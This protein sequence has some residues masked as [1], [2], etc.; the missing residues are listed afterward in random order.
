MGFPILVRWHLS[1]ESG[2]R[3]WSFLTSTHWPI[4]V[5]SEASWSA[6]HQGFFNIK[7]IFPG[8]RIAIINIRWP[9]Y[10]YNGNSYTGKMASLYRSSPTDPSELW[11]PVSASPWARRAG[12]SSEVV[13]P[14]FG[15]RITID[16]EVSAV[17]LGPTCLVA[18]LRNG[19]H[20][21]IIRSSIVGIK[22]S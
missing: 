17:H 1:F 12:G 11:G 16:L 8:I 9:C 4:H 21:T 5:L 2:P 22:Q 7:T 6:V 14:H 13:P 15:Q 18:V 20:L 10:L 3:L 19:C